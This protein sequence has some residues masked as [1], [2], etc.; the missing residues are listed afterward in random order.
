MNNV[1]QLPNKVNLK[2]KPSKANSNSITDQR[3][4]PK[5]IKSIGSKYTV[6]ND[7]INK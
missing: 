6:P 5:P 3:F 7:I 4:Q 1:Q 2:T